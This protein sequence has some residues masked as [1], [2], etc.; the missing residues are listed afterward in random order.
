MAARAW[1]AGV[2]GSS[3]SSRPRGARSWPCACAATAQRG[4]NPLAA[5]LMAAG[6]G[7]VRRREKREERRER[8]KGTPVHD[9]WG[10]L[11]VGPG[12]VGMGVGRI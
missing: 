11:G 9:R 10:P 1:A 8:G 7:E 2:Q 5:P 6:D 3:V 4:A 12:R